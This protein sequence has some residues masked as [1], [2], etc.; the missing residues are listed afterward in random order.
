MSSRACIASLLALALSGCAGMVVTT[1]KTGLDGKTVVTSSD[2]AEQERID[3]AEREKE[4]YAKAIAEAPRRAAQDIIEVAVFESTVS[5][6]LS[7]SLDRKQL[8]ESLPRE[9]STDSRL[10]VVPV[11]ALSG[12]AARAGASAEDRIDAARAKGLSP[13]V[14]ILPRV[15]LE[16]AVGTSGG[17]LTSVKAFTLHGEAVSAYGTGASQAKEQGTILQNVQVVK[18]A[19]TK[20]RTVILE[21][22]G[23]NLPSRKAV[24]GLQEERRRKQMASIEEQAGIQP[25]DDAQTRLRKILEAAKRGNQPAQAATQE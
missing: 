6:E 19:A 25:E 1:T 18:N 9:L 14:W 12:S 24:A 4:A 5:E 7:K 23:P 8:D 3:A 20:T 16:D 13:D 17:K 2:P 10:H 21:Q 11:G 22:L 15:F